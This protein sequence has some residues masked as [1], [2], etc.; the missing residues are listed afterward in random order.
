VVADPKDIS[1]ELQVL[2][3]LVRG[4]V[5]LDADGQKLS[6]KE[7]LARMRAATRE[8]GEFNRAHRAQ[9][10]VLRADAALGSLDTQKDPN[11]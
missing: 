4:E 11:G 6:E 1:K 10:R 9:L 5:V 7:R 3:R 2:W 8:V